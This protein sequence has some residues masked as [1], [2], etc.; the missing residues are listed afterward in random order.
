MFKDLELTHEEASRLSRAGIIQPSEKFGMRLVSSHILCLPSNSAD[1]HQGASAPSAT[2]S[3]PTRARSTQE[4]FELPTIFESIT[5]LE[6]VGLTPGAARVILE[7]FEDAPDFDYTLPVLEDYIVQ[8]FALADN[9]RDPRE[10]MTL[11]GINREIQDAILDPEFREVFKTQSVMHWVEDTIEMNCKTLRIQMHALKEQARAERDKA[12]FDLSLLSESLDKAAAS[13]PPAEIPSGAPADRQP[14]S[15]YLPQTCVIAQDP[16]AIPQG[17]RALYTNVVLNSHVTLFGPYDNINL[18]G[19]E[20]CRGGDFHGDCSAI[21]LVTE[22]G[23][24]ELERRYT[25]RRCPLSESWTA[26]IL[27][28]KDFVHS[29]RYNRLYYSPEWKYVVWR[30]RQQHVPEDPFDNF[31]H[32][33]LMIGHKCKAPSSEIRRI[34]REDLQEAITDR[35][36]MTFNG[37]PVEQWVFRNEGLSSLEGYI[38]GNLHVEVHAPMAYH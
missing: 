2:A 9:T 8:H 16:P 6:Y 22:K 12:A 32:A 34:N 7:N 15:T 31:T 20:K 36:V 23:V 27:V 10:A 28:S 37:V 29:L 19:I 1:A 24:A 30:N 25:A 35:H 21:P 13:N 18:Y 33:H 38:T 26:R 11:C 14:W 5:A 17:Y 3:F 4:W